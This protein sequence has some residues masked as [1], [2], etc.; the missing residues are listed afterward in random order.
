MEISTRRDVERWLA[1]RSAEVG[2]SIAARASLRVIPILA[3]AIRPRVG[4]VSAVA[5]DIVLPTLRANA[6]SW[7]AATTPVHTS[8]LRKAAQSAAADAERAIAQAKNLDRTSPD[9]IRAAAA[10]ARAV[11]VNSV[12]LNLEAA[13]AVASAA[14]SATPQAIYA[15]VAADAKQ[16][17][18]GT[19]ATALALQPLWPTKPP[20]WSSALGLIARC[21]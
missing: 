15:A 1:D 14:N 18:A 5:T 12:N 16:V 6:V 17:D 10:A 4:L 21:A 13:R 7:A 3:A 20:S 19:P 8:N 2:I 11:I 9:P